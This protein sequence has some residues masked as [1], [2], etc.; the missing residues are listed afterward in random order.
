[1]RVSHRK[2]DPERSTPERPFLTHDEIQK[3]APGEVVA[4]EV[5]IWRPSPTPTRVIPSVAGR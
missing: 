4:V 2:L 3:T 5:E 1:V